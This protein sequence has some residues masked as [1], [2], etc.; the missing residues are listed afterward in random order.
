MIKK[1]IALSLSVFFMSSFAYTSDDIAGANALASKKIIKDWSSN[2]EKYRFDD[3]IARSEIMG[4]IL[5]MK[6]IVRN[7][8][9]RGDFVDVPKSDIDW[10]CRTVETA[11][12]N[13][14]INATPTDG[15]IRPY[16]DVSRAEAL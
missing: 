3:P 10:V 14:L 6:N 8:N 1:Y 13:G 11:A 7:E 9:C 12:D 15:K 2:P 5:A 16:A 4:M